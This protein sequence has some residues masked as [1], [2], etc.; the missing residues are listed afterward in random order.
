M[1]HQTEQQSVRLGDKEKYLDQLIGKNERLKEEYEELTDK[2]RLQQHYATLKLQ[3]KIKQEEI[4]YYRDLERKFKQIVN[5]WKK[6]E[7]KNEV[8]S[9]AEK[10]LFKKRAIQQNQQAANKADKN[11]KVLGNEAKI[12]DFLRNKTNHQIGRLMAIDG[13]KG[14]L[15]I[16]KLPFSIKLD[17]WITVEPRK[18]KRKPTTGLSDSGE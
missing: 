14:T 1:L 11:Y 6:T 9:N 10:V 13:K 18:K 16:G 12:G 4:D 3:N 5:D 15:K 7:N 2:E 17:E 8:I